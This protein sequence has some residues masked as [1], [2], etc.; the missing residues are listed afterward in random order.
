[1]WRSTP[2]ENR[3][4]TICIIIF[5]YWYYF[6]FCIWRKQEC[7]SS[8]WRYIETNSWSLSFTTSR[9]CYW[10]SWRE[11]D[12]QG[13]GLPKKV[14]STEHWT[15]DVFEEGTDWSV[16]V[17]VGGT[18]QFC[19]VILKDDIMKLSPK[20]EVGE[21]MWLD[22]FARNKN[23]KYLNWNSI[24]FSSRLACQI[25]VVKEMNGTTIFVVILL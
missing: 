16:D 8:D 13:L 24:S 21:Q 7:K 2:I 9:Y 5:Q 18:C 14:F 3:F 11:G 15:N 19:H 17:I 25:R 10:C 23:K 22:K 1:M 4:L 12:C 6:C 20:P